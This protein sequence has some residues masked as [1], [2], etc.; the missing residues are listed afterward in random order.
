MNLYE[1]L[2]VLPKRSLTNLRG[3]LAKTREHAAARG[4]DPDTLLTARLAPDQ[5]ALALQVQIACSDAAGNAARLSGKEVLALPNEETSLVQLEARIDK[6]VAF[7]DTFAPSDFEG[8]ETRPVSLGWMRGRHMVGKE[9]VEEFA[10][11]N[12]YF[13]VSHAYAILRHSGVPLGKGDYVGKLSIR[14]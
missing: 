10:L 3:C 1:L 14:A 9:Y 8:A 11:A 12:F 4:F 13:H 2:V 7:L 6:V 5:F